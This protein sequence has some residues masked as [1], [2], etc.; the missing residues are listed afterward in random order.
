[1]YGVVSGKTV[2]AFSFFNTSMSVD[3][4]TLEL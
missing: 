2:T 3:R 1:M 4:G